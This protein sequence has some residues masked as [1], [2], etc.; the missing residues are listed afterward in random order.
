M[1][2]QTLWA[3]GIAAT[4]LSGCGGGGSHEPAVTE[5]VPAA[6]SSDPVVATD[7]V[8]ALAAVPAST[9]SAMPNSGCVAIHAV[10]TE[11]SSPPTASTAM[12]PTIHGVRRAPRSEPCPHAGLNTCSA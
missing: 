12:P 10:A 8:A 9:A 5:A 1:S 11:A 2:K 4:L 7:Y 6:A 3:M